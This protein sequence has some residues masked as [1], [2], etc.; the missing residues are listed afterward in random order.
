MRGLG[1]AVREGLGKP[2]QLPK[3]MPSVGLDGRSEEHGRAGT[4]GTRWWSGPF[5]CTENSDPL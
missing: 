4:L 1:L 2:E 5:S 3:Q